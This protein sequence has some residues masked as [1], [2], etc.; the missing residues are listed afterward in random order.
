MNKSEKGLA[1]DPLI[2]SSQLR[3]VEFRSRPP[4]KGRASSGSTFV[5]KE[6]EGCENEAFIPRAVEH[7]GLDVQSGESVR[8]VVFSPQLVID[9]SEG[10]PS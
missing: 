6:A 10:Q 7:I 9:G 4:G 8:R 5:V 3:V 2:S 1:I